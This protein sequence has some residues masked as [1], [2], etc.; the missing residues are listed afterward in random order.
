MNNAAFARFL[1]SLG[2]DRRR[3]TQLAADGFRAADPFVVAVRLASIGKRAMPSGADKVPCISGWQDKATTNPATLAHWYKTKAAPCWSILTGRANGVVV[4]DIDGE[5]GLHDL[6]ALESEYGALPQTLRVISGRVGGGLHIW[7][8]PPAGTDDLRNQQSFTTLADGRKI[9][10]DIRGWHGHTVIP[11][12]KHK[13]GNRYRWVEGCSPDECELAECPMWLWELLPKKEHANEGSQRAAR[14]GAGYVKSEYD[15]GSWLFGDGDGRGA[16]QGPINK[17]A[18]RYFRL[19][20]VDADASPLIEFLRE[21]IIA[22]KK[23]P[24]REQYVQDKYLAG[25]E[26]ERLVERARKYVKE[27]S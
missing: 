12:S 7:F 20:G 18:I 3:A 5:Q 15:P 10:W 27:T 9:K 11:G 26:L 6:A 2:Y 22:A 25:P 4:I 21:Q 16:F 17:W 23:G 1:V 24:G 13:S 19:E 8:R 14:T